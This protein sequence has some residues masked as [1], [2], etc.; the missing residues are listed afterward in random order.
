MRRILPIDL[1]FAENHSFSK[2]V[3]I[4]LLRKNELEGYP[5]RISTSGGIA[6]V[7][8]QIYEIKKVRIVLADLEKEGYLSEHKRYIRGKY[9][10]RIYRLTDK[11]IREYDFGMENYQ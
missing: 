1:A 10:I 6:R 7:Y 8:P 11:A 9:P 2:A 3:L 4:A 5:D